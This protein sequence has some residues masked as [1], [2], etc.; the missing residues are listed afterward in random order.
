MCYQVLLTS[1]K[2]SCVL[3]HSLVNDCL[4]DA[5]LKLDLLTATIKHQVAPKHI[6]CEQVSIQYSDL[7]A[8]NTTL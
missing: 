4:S 1:G 5:V 7:L 6:K 8:T 3:H 2:Q